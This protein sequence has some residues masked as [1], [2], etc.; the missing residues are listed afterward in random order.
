MNDEMTI[1]KRFYIPENYVVEDVSDQLIDVITKLKSPQITT[2]AYF[3][4]LPVVEK[5][6]KSFEKIHAALEK[7]INETV[8]DKTR[9][10]LRREFEKIEE[11]SVEHFNVESV[12]INVITDHNTVTSIPVSAGKIDLKPYENLGDND[13][14][15]EYSKIEVNPRKGIKYVHKQGHH[16]VV[17]FGMGIL[18]AKQ[19]TP[20]HL[21]ALYFHEIGHSFVQHKTGWHIGI[22]RMWYNADL[23]VRTGFIVFSLVNNIFNIKNQSK[24]V[25]PAT[26]TVVKEFKRNRDIEK[27]LGEAK[28]GL[29][30][31]WGSWIYNSKEKVQTI[32]SGG[33][34]IL[35]SLY[36]IIG[37]ISGV[38]ANLRDFWEYLFTDNK[39]INDNIKKSRDKLLSGTFVI[40]KHE[41]LTLAMQ[42]YIRQIINIFRTAFSILV[43]GLPM[44]AITTAFRAFLIPG[45]WTGRK[46]EYASDEIA[47][48]YGLGPEVAE[49]F[50]IMRDVS[51]WQDVTT[52]GIFK[53]TNK[54]PVLNVIAQLPMALIAAIETHCTGHPTDSARIR[55]MQK[56]LLSEI[57]QQKLNPKLEAALLN[58]LHRIDETYN[59]HTDPYLNAEENRHASA[60]IFF[61]TRLVSGFYSKGVPKSNNSPSDTILGLHA[62]TTWMKSPDIKKNLKLKGEGDK[63]IIESLEGKLPKVANESSYDVL[64]GEIT[65]ESTFTDAEYEAFNSITYE[66]YFG[67][68]PIVEHSIEYVKNIRS[69]FPEKS[70]TLSTD[71]KKAIK[72]ILSRWSKEISNEFNVEDTYVGLENVY[73]AYAYPLYTGNSTQFRAAK[74]AKVLETSHGF[75]F[76]KSENLFFIIVVGMRLLTDPK[77]SDETVTAVLFHELGHGFQQYKTTSIKKQRSDAIIFNMIGQIKSFLYAAGSLQITNALKYGFSIITNIFLRFGIGRDRLKL[78]EETEHDTTKAMDNTAFKDGEAQAGKSNNVYNPLT[79]IILGLQHLVAITVSMIPIPGVTAFIS[80]IV[81]DPLFLLDLAVRGM[82]FARKKRDEHFADSFAMMYG[83]GAQMSQLNYRFYEMDLENVCS[84]PVLKIASQFNMLGTVAMLSALDDHPTHRVRIKATYES[85]EKELSDNK[86][87]PPKLREQAVADIEA[88]KSVYNDLTS[89]KE[90]IKNGRIGQGLVWFCIGVFVQLKKTAKDVAEFISPVIATTPQILKAG[91][92]SFAKKQRV[93][94]E[95]GGTLAEAQSY[96]Q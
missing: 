1:Q 67:R 91:V 5:I 63:L 69:E 29:E 38:I 52:K 21:A 79:L 8:D 19:F 72:E 22:Q 94:E 34:S 30:E 35:R 27:K 76:D 66:G 32:F 77:L 83:L 28:Y 74:A 36:I 59:Q 20:E 41:D 92:E 82:Y 75:K 58:D 16:I 44:Y 43:F 71:A 37:C 61:I 12:S 11:E 13:A 95:L 39:E 2:E 10:V 25:V 56:Q 64:D 60:F 51:L 86:N 4:K 65:M 54:V 68:T 55:N 15:K 84:I 80:T 6:I 93:R 3:G 70:G 78:I 53:L 81:Y 40:G 18:A 23:A 33:L 96:L 7:R 50:K 42:V 89:P 90:N 49:A 9:D 24:V 26:T 62:L 85:L 14:M 57:D 87:L 48:A 46:Y 17:T 47:M 73:N 45:V 31:V 88:I